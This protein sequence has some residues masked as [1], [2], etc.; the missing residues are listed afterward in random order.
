MPEPEPRPEPQ[1]RVLELEDSVISARARSSK[2]DR[3]SSSEFVEGW[4][5]FSLICSIQSMMCFGD[6]DLVTVALDS[7]EWNI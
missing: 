1:V 5:S 6:F 4:F 2:E 3:W 7:K